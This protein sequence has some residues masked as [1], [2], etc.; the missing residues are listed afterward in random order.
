MRYYLT[1]LALLSCGVAQAASWSQQQLAEFAD[2]APLTFGVVSNADDRTKKMRLSLDN[3]SDMALPSSGWSVYFHLV[4]KVAP[5]ADA[6]VQI[7]HVQGDLHRLYPTSDF[8]GLEPGQSLSVEFSPSAHMVSYSDFMPRAFVVMGELEPEVF[9]NTDTETLTDFVEPIVRQEQQLRNRHDKFQVMTA[10]TRYQANKQWSALEPQA[11]EHRIVP[12]PLES[13]FRRGSVTLDDSWQIRY[14]GRLKWE[15]QYLIERLKTAYGIELEAEPD[16]HSTKKGPVIYLRV[17][18]G[19]VKSAELPEVSEGYVL[20]VS[21]ERIVIDGSDSAGAFYGIQSLLGLMG[22]D[23]AQLPEVLISD[24]PRAHW[25]GMH[26]D[27]GRNFHGLDVTLRMIEQMGRYKLNK[28]HLHLTEDEGWRLEIPG[29]PELTEVGANRC[30]DMSEQRCLLTQLGTGPH[31]SGSGNGFYSADDFV[32][33]LK[34]AAARHIEVIPEIDMPGH[35]RAAIKSMEARYQ[36]L[37]EAGDKA[38]AEQYLLSDPKDASEYI[39]VQNYTDN[40]INV[41]LESTYRFVD[42]VIYELQQMYRRAG[43]KLDTFHMGGDEVGAGSWTASPACSALFTSELGVAGPAD[44]KPYFV[45][46]VSQ[47][48][49]ERGLDLAGWEDGLMYDPNNT[50]NRAQFANERVIAN[51]WDN[52][53]EWGVADRA[54]RLANA[55]Y[56]VVLSHGTHLYFDHP[57]EVNPHERGYYWAARYTDLAKVFGYMPDNLYANADFTRNGDP[58]DNLEALVG[59]PLP[60][61]EKPDNILGIQG[62]VWTETIRTPEQLEQ[63]VYPRLLALAE[64]AWHKASWEGTQPATEQRLEDYRGFLS[65]FEKELPRLVAA[66]VSPYLPPPGAVLDDGVLRAN[67]SLP[68]ASIEYSLDKGASWQAYDK[69]VRLEATTVQLRSRFDEQSSRVVTLEN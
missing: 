18:G 41:C 14:A 37:M 19:G 15:A 20:E 38:A 4:R 34:Y 27:M 55:G 53:W 23:K 47:V 11:G 68:S 10:E 33:I 13:K 57:H 59:R 32:A 21:D 42:K 67:S 2:T 3:Q 54:H 64:R 46:R 51:V 48:V 29:L 28:L 43:I 1:L 7:E 35:A 26:Y 60:P 6:N 31:E 17:A 44:L 5:L 39:T 24:A 8:K 9:A 63:M 25:R 69:P 58:I 22:S 12:K 50:F 52:I 16:H 30:F 40:S 45:S 36:R 49:S 65:S 62:Q 56:Q 61:L 66:G